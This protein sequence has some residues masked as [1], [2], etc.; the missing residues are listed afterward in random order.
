MVSKMVER[1]EKGISARGSRKKSKEIKFERCGI[2]CGLNN[3]TC[4]KGTFF[5]IEICLG[6]VSP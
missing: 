3:E 6:R 2:C 4:F 1:E 5:A